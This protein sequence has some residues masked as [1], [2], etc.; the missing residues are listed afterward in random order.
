M[1]VE[2]SIIEKVIHRSLLN[3]NKKFADMGV[4]IG[5]GSEDTIYSLDCGSILKKY[6]VFAPMGGFQLE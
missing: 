2:K 6:H 3:W 1:K 4:L 5:E